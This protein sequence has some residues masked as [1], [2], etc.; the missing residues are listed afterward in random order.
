M[1]GMPSP[2]IISKIKE[3][4]PDL[5]VVLI[6]GSSEKLQTAQEKETADYYLTKPFKVDEFQKIMRIVGNLKLEKAN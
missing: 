4:R 5:P 1:P 2:M 6:S 3:K